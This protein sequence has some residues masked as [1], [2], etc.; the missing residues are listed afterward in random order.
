MMKIKD[1]LDDV[2]KEMRKVSW[3]SR[4]EVISNTVITVFA[5][6]V[7]SLFIYGADQVISTIL[8]FVYS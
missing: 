5:S 6:F 4:N 8:E 1:Y 3:P 7:V 2:V